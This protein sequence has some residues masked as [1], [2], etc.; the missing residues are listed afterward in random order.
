MTTRLSI[1]QIGKGTIGAT[2]IDQVAAR[3]EALRRDPGIDLVY[4]GVAG[5]TA[6]AFDPNGLD[7][8]R[9]RKAVEAGSGLDGRRLVLE[10]AR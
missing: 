9:W 8:A 5:R 4:A 2:L 3:Q 10:A 7:L 6:G 1:I